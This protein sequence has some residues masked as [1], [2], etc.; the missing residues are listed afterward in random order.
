MKG[1]SVSAYRNRFHKNRLKNG[2]F[3]TCKKIF[4]EE[5]IGICFYGKLEYLLKEEKK[6]TTICTMRN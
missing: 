5:Q 6:V 1:F 2:V 3:F 4:Q